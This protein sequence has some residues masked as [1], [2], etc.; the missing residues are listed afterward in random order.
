MLRKYWKLLF[1]FFLVV[2]FTGFYANKDIYF[3]ISKNIDLFG[4]VYKE[5]TLNYVDEI[6]LEE[7]M[8]TGI[9][10]MLN[11]LD[12]YTVFID[13]SK[14]DEIELITNGKYAGVGISVAVRGDKVIISEVFDGYAAQ[15][16]GIHTGD[17][18]VGV[19]N[20]AISPNNYEQISSL[21]KGEPGTT[22]DMTI[23]R[24]NEQDT[25]N[26]NIV[27]E[28]ISVKNLAYYGFYPK[29]SNNVYLKLI[30]FSRSAGEEVRQALKELESQKRIESIVLD[31]RN[32]PGGLLDAAVQI[33]EKF[34]DK[35]QIIVSTR[36]RDASKE[37]RYYSD[38]NPIMSREKLIVL[39]NDGSASASEIVAGA[40]Q[41]HDRGLIIGTKTFGK[42]LVQTISNLG[43][44]TQLKITTAK[45]YTPSG[46]CIQKIDYSSRNHVI[47][48]ADTIVA[49]RFLTDNSREVFSAGGITPDSTIE[50]EIESGLTQE[51]FAQ[52]MFFRFADYYTANNEDIKLS[53]LN[54][55]ELISEFQKFLSKE[56][57][58]YKSDAEKEIDKL[59]DEAK[60]KKLSADVFIDLNRIKTQFGSLNNNEIK[61]YRDEILSEIRSEIALKINGFNGKTEELL[62]GDKQFQAAFNIAS[63]NE[64]FKKLLNSK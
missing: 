16:Q 43:Y 45:Y 53:S 26:F 5:V 17:V 13:D 3:E 30:G 50:F 24:N 36:G 11:S 52:G 20:V 23:V 60:N 18:L 46:R 7:F 54:N 19:S 10:G 55:D 64:L 38:E 61:I 32:N 48:K 15:K 29:N 62:N 22:V 12:P 47:S 31:L 6:D 40:I 41:D 35:D 39:V 33:C 42:G 56:K 2:L 25:I 27:R 57:F 51:L 59:Y 14:K 8:K 1:G 37:K 4:K 63:N 28:E 58:V 9:Q 21:I 34:L 49:A 44:N